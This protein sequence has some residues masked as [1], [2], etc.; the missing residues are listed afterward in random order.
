MFLLRNI[1]IS[2]AAILFL[3]F[4]LPLLAQPD[5]DLGTGQLAFSRTLATVRGHQLS[6]PVNI[7]YS[8]R[9][10]RHQRA[11]WAGLGFTVD[12]PYIERTVRGY[13]DERSGSSELWGNGEY[14]EASY[15][16][17]KSLR[18]DLAPFN[19][20][21]DV[22]PRPTL[23]VDLYYYRKLF[24]NWHS[25]PRTETCPVPDH[26]LPP[27][28]SCFG[29]IPPMTCDLLDN[30]TQQDEYS[31]NLLPAGGGSIFFSNGEL[32]SPIITPLRSWI[33]RCDTSGGNIESWTI[34]DES[35]TE[36][37]FNACVRVFPGVQLADLAYY[38]TYENAKITYFQAGQAASRHMSTIIDKGHYEYSYVKRWYLTRMKSHDG[39]T[40]RITYDPKGDFSLSENPYITNINRY[41]YLDTIGWTPLN[42]STPITQIDH[43]TQA[44]V[45]NK[46]EYYEATVS[47]SQITS[48]LQRL[49]FGIGPLPA[50][51]PVSELGRD[52]LNSIALYDLASGAL[53]E[54]DTFEYSEAGFIR[55]LVNGNPFTH[56]LALDRIKKKKAGSYKLLYEFG[57]TSGI[58]DDYFGTSGGMISSIRDLN[59][60]VIHYGY[61][62]G[63]CRALSNMQS[64][65][66]SLQNGAVVTGVT[67]EAGGG[68]P[69]VNY[70]LTYSDG[71]MNYSPAFGTI[72][73][74]GD[75]STDI[76]GV[77][78]DIDYN[79]KW[80]AKFDVCL[81]EF[82]VHYGSVTVNVPGAGK[83]IHT[84][85]TAWDSYRVPSQQDPNDSFS[86]KDDANE[87]NIND[88]YR[89]RPKTV[90]EY[91]GGNTQVKRTEY[92]YSANDLSIEGNNRYFKPQTFAQHYSFIIND[93][94]MPYYS[95]LAYSDSLE[96]NNYHQFGLP[97]AEMAKLVD[98]KL[99]RVEE[100]RDSALKTTDNEYN[101]FGL[102]YKESVCGRKGDTL[103]T[104]RYYTGSD[105]AAYFH[106]KNL[107]SGV[108]YSQT[109]YKKDRV[110]WALSNGS[111]YPTRY[112]SW[113]GA[114]WAL[115]GENTRRNASGYL[116][117]SRTNA[118]SLPVTSVLRSDNFS[119][120]GQVVNGKYLESAI[121]T[122]DY[123]ANGGDTNYFDL[124]NGWQR[125]GGILTSA[126]VHFSTKSVYVLN[127]FGPSRNFKIYPGKD[128]IMSAWVRPIVDSVLMWGDYRLIQN[129]DTTLPLDVGAFMC[130][131][132]GTPVRVK[133]P[134]DWQYIEAR[135]H[136]ATDITAAYWNAFPD[137][138][139]A[140]VYV[141]TSPRGQAYI[142]DIRIYPADAQVTTT[143]YDSRNRVVCTV[144]ANN[145]ASYAEYDTWDRAVRTKN[146]AKKTVME[147]AYK[148]SGDLP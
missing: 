96:F 80:A 104:I 12:M 22:P 62:H 129:V 61:N 140:R 109:G 144:D 124:A 44:V 53:M 77:L 11:S 91:S 102:L 45:K 116:L 49:V 64:V 36:Y 47:P 81:D 66:Y 48:A 141:G 55:P 132:S 60:G 106:T 30:C 89:Y 98:V 42:P 18:D 86:L 94:A 43:V 93:S 13:P 133:A 128:Y 73:T 70:A 111:Y 6:L 76:N 68:A 15:T 52:R 32:S 3:S 27:R 137:K 1:L 143:Y 120:I 29:S 34:I 105:T 7:S 84:F 112:L 114:L 19:P 10:T 72:S 75:V 119:P 146:N 79:E 9:I 83:S 38:R 28:S 88:L 56:L 82:P 4:N 26:A 51:A 67:V 115:N 63:S 148:L 130:A 103:T 92:T 122:C 40:L 25:T 108:T 123:S 41:S 78:G 20:A 69:L 95:C 59:G 135:I 5:V 46:T 37:T 74:D 142:D 118:G 121:Y 131:F 87:Y 147:K 90:Y 99:T 16:G 100:F 113:D 117:E 23:M 58:G 134:G 97:E 65:Q 2:L 138:W 139:C 35:G 125:G 14:G 136:A 17:V 127:N 85:Y 50:N 24:G 31:L 107:L 71:E 145:H 21:I 101:A 39:D 8:S 33:I 110:E 126:A 57:Y 54:K